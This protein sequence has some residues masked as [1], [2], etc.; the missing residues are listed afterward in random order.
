MATVTRGVDLHVEDFAG[1]NV[2]RL[3]K[4]VPNSASNRSRFPPHLRTTIVSEPGVR[5]GNI[6]KQ[7]Q[8]VFPFQSPLREQVRQF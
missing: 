8:E 4:N 2:S 1:G 5:V 3:S 7:A 6:L